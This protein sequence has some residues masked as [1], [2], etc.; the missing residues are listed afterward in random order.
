M[1]VH[2]H[3]DHGARAEGKRPRW[4]ASVSPDGCSSLPA[5][6]SCDL[7][8]SPA[9]QVGL[10]VVAGFAQPYQEWQRGTP[11]IS[12]QGSRETHVLCNAACTIT[13]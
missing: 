12:L 1:R 5:Y 7:P 9:Q 3:K 8:F 4:S 10:F 6:M 13:G 2:R 11:S